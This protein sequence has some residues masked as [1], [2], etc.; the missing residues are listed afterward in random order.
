M[1][2]LD[3]E[4]TRVAAIVVQSRLRTPSE[5]AIEEMRKSMESIGL[6]APIGVRIIE[7]MEVCGEIR[8]GVPILV[9]GAT[10]LEAARRIG[11]EFIDTQIVEADDIDAGLAEID[12]N[13]ARHELTTD[14]KKA[15][16]RKRKELWELRQ[17]ENGKSLPIF[18]KAGRGHRGFASETAAATGLSER[19]VNQ[20]LADPKPAAPKPAKVIDYTEV[21]SSRIETDVKARAAK[22]VAEILA[23]HIPGEFWDGLKANLYSAG[24]TNVAHAFTNLIGNSVMDRRYGQ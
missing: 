20:L 14:E 19:R 17:T 23:E 7:E 8:C 2:R 15:H 21:T 3:V 1:K 4:P 22:E 24:A 11:W 6:L 13:L 9:Y 18:G 10:R 5:E 16:V 12:E